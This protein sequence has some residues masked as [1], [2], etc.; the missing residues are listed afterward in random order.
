MAKTLQQILGAKNLTG[1]IKG[2][3][4]GIPQDILPPAFLK[5]TRT[6][7][8]DYC[9]YRKV[10]GTRKTA[11]LA[12]YG[13]PSRT[14]SLKGVSEVPVKLVHSI[15]S[16]QHTPATLM[17]LTNMADE[18]RQKLGIQEVTRQTRDFK[19]LFVNLR[20]ASVYAM[21]AAGVIYF[22]VDGELL[23]DSTGAFTTVDAQ[24][25]SGNKDQLDVFG[26]GAIIAASWAT[27][28]TAINTQISNLKIA[29][30][31]KT[32]Y[33]LRQAFYGNNI[34][35]YFLGNTKLKE[36][37][38][39]NAGYQVAAAGGEIPQGFL[40]L[41]WTPVQ[42]AFYED[43]DGEY[44]EFFGG[45]TVVFTPDP[46]P[47]W[48]EFIEGT[49]PVA[50]DIGKVAADAVAALRSIKIE[51]GMFSFATVTSDPAGIK[52]VAGDTFLPMIKVP[53]AVFMADVTP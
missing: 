52:Q 47:D 27:A 31:K 14:R 50:G 18:N 24:V 6:V 43:A 26:D 46:S 41:N 21:L 2:V 37:I 17:N 28:G 51:S 22:D 38:N 5:P 11:R 4:P 29:A 7:E 44:Q 19:D 40:G 12:Q 8:G 35:N 16:M 30:R 23:P 10:D 3:A 32:G 39:R 13:A 20:Y 53:G 33:P 36:L 9:T 15:E 49:Y 48:Y 45:D 1:V 42:E 25:P 34:L